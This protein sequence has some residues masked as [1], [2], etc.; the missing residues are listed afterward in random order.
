M[1]KLRLSE[2]KSHAQGPLEELKLRSPD[3][4]WF[5]L[6]LLRV[7]GGPPGRLREGPVWTQVGDGAE[8]PSLLQEEA[9]DPAICD[10][11]KKVKRKLGTFF[12]LTPPQNKTC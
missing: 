1:K 4:L 10:P 8:S 5:S 9:L 7:D 3:A 12:W 6:L 2:A 11:R